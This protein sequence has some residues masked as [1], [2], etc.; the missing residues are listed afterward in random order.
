MYIRKD[1]IK[2][3]ENRICQMKYNW[4]NIGKPL[5]LWKNLEQSQPRY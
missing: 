2:P 4:D 1:D 5:I 3:Y